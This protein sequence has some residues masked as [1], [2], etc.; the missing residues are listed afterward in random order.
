M[1]WLRFKALAGLKPPAATGEVIGTA[2]CKV[3]RQGGFAHT[4]QAVNSPAGCR[5]GRARYAAQGQFPQ[6]R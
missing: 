4:W 1:S 6:R 5:Q 2:D 3:E